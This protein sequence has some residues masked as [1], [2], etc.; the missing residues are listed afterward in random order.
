MQNQP[1]R[2]EADP[3]SAP[4]GESRPAFPTHA[5]VGVIDTAAE[6]SRAEEALRAAGFDESSVHVISGDHAVEV[7]DQSGTGHGLSGR[8]TRMAQALFG[9]ETEH[10]ERHVQEVKAG[11]YLVLVSSHDDEATERIRGILAAN[12][13]HFVNYYT[14]WTSRVLVP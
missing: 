13:G 11:H 3:A 7:I 10:T 14:N 2:E 5:V 9:M 1:G 8:L 4:D 12:G 6:V